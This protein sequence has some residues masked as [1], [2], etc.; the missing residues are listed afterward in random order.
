MSARGTIYGVGLGPGDPELMTVKAH[1]LVTTARRV[2][3][4]RKRERAGQARRIVEGLLP[5]D[6][7]EIAMEY[8][9]T[10]EIP[11][12][13]PAY[14]A[15]LRPFYEECA[16]KLVAAASE[17]HDVVVL[18]EGDPFLYGSFAHLHVR[19]A[20][21]ETVVVVPGVPGMA[22]CW[23]A[24]GAPVTFGDDVLTVLP[25]TLPEAALAEKLRGG[26]AFVVMKLGRNLAKLKRA[27]AAA[28]LLDRAVY[29]ER[30]TMPGERVAPLAAVEDDAAPYFSMALVH[31]RGRRP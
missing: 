16:A 8:P 29:V 3:F 30:G 5:P 28:G 12:D 13:D 7:V 22:G 1:R 25:A 4:F 31:G 6:A 15:A 19:L 24:S 17:G 23:S 14:A 18:C 2:A 21:S 20:A 26:D 27:L 10:T 11:F 9:V